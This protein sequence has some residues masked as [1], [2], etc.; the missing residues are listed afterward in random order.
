MLL[1]VFFLF[2]QKRRRDALH[3]IKKKNGIRTHNITIQHNHTHKPNTPARTHTY[4]HTHGSGQEATR[5]LNQTN[6]RPNST[7]TSLS[8]QDASQQRLQQGIGTPRVST[9]S[10]PAGSAGLGFCPMIPDAEGYGGGGETT[11]APMPT[12]LHPPTLGN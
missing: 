12:K 11:E 3:S 9:L 2:F 7:T 1:Y 6:K 4:K 10:A 5:P 8:S